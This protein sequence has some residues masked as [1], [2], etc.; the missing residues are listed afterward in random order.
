MAKAKRRGRP[1]RLNVR[2]KPCGRPSD[3]V[4]QERVRATP[5]YEARKRAAFGRA[6]HPWDPSDPIDRLCYDGVI[7][8]NQRRAAHQYRA[9]SWQ[10]CGRP[11]ADAA[12]W[13][14]R[15]PDPTPEGV[16]RVKTLEYR[17]ATA[18][19]EKAGSLEKAEVQR[20]AV[21]M[22][23]PFFWH[24]RQLKLGLA[25]LERFF[26]SYRQPLQGG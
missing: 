9:L 11:H 3:S 2:R 16:L 15:R 4:Y 18:A 7:D 10:V 14:E 22:A 20:V 23:P 17:A 19:L 13:D 26:G 6:D 5:E 24:R 1:R 8:D 25:A 21:E 12:W